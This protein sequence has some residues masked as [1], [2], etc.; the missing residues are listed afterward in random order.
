MGISSVAPR[1]SAAII[2]LQL[3]FSETVER[4]DLMQALTE[5]SPCRRRTRL[6]VRVFLAASGLSCVPNCIGSLLLVCFTPAHPSSLPETTTDASRHPTMHRKLHSLNRALHCEESSPRYL[7][8]W[9]CNQRVTGHGERRGC[10][11]HKRECEPL[12]GALY[13]PHQA[14]FTAQLTRQAGTESRRGSAQGD[15]ESHRRCR[16]LEHR[17]ETAP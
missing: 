3:A 6:F 2:V 1:N 4:L 17:L 15:A 7:V 11:A 5:P 8:E 14:I 12:K 9:R 10:L 13:S 16:H